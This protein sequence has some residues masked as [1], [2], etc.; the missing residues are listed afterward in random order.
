M[1]NSSLYALLGLAA[2]ETQRLPG[3]NGAETAGGTA[4]LDENTGE[5]IGYE[6]PAVDDPGYANNCQ[7]WGLTENC[8][9]MS[10]SGDIDPTVYRAKRWQV[11]AGGP[12]HNRLWSANEGWNA[13]AIRVTLTCSPSVNDNRP[14]EDAAGTNKFAEYI[15]NGIEDSDIM[16]RYVELTPDHPLY[17]T[18]PDPWPVYPCDVP[19]ASTK[20]FSANDAYGSLMRPDFTRFTPDSDSN[21]MI[22]PNPNDPN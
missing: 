17:N 6:P 10:G 5:V 21:G 22:I 2:A 8:D 19:D 11:I 13:E 9:Y 4:I 16:H 20:S 7:R 18:D 15:F 14:N 12:L 3:Y 1:K